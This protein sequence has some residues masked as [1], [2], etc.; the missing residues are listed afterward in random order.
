MGGGGGSGKF[1]GTRGGI[2]KISGSKMYQDGKH[3][4]KHGREMGYS[5]KNEYN[6]AAKNFAIKYQNHPDAKIYE[7]VWNGKGVF[8]E[9]VQ[10]II[11]Y[12]NMT[13]IIDPKTGQIIDFYYGDEYRGFIDLQRLR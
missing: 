11:T 7:G 6:N 13:V 10:R 4:N 2:F 9:Q 5:S 1:K 12:G 3:Y 8:H